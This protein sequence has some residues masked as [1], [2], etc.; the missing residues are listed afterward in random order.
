M[1][2]ECVAESTEHQLKELLG[3]LVVL[4][5]MGLN[6]PKR[7]KKLDPAL[8]EGYLQLLQSAEIQQVDRGASKSVRVIFDV[9]PKLLEEAEGSVAQADPPK[10]DH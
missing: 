2:G 8:R 3:G 5:Q 4:A 9:T 6:D 1:E 7:Q 10:A